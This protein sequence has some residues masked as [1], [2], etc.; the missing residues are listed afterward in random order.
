MPYLGDDVFNA[1]LDG[2]L[3]YEHLSLGEGFAR[4][5]TITN[6]DVGRFYPVFPFI[7][8]FDFHVVHDVTVLKAV[9]LAA[10][11]ANA[12]TFYALVRA[13]APSLALP[14]LVVLPATLQLRFFHDAI[15]QF[16]LHMQVAFEFALLG[17]LCVVV[18]ARSRRIVLAVLSVTACALAALTYEATYA[19]AVIYVF[20]AGTLVPDVRARIR[21]CIAYVLV[22][23]GCCA[24]VLAVR[25]RVPVASG[26]SY[27]VNLDAAAV[28]HTVWLQ[29]LGALPLSYAFWNPTGFLPPLPQLWDGLACWGV[30][31]IEFGLALAVLLRVG[32]A[33]DGGREGTAFVLGTLLVTLSG[34]PIAVLA[35]WQRELG[36]GL[37]YT[38]VYF[39][40]F[41]MALVIAAFGFAVVRRLPRVTSAV[42]LALAAAFLAGTTY[43]ANGLVL[44]HYVGWS[45]VVPRALDA[46]L[47]SNARTG[48]TVYLDDSYPAHAMKTASYYL[49]KH[50]HERLTARRQVD[51]P[52]IVGPGTF[53]LDGSVE[54]FKTGRVVAGRIVSVVRVAGENVPLVL[55]A[56][57][58]VAGAGGATLD[59]IRSRCGLLPLANL[60]DDIP[61]ALLVRYGDAFSFPERDGDATFR[62]ASEAGRV[63]VDNP[64]ARARR[65]TVSFD[66]RPAAATSHVSVRSGTFVLD[67]ESRGGDVP[68]TLAVD[69]PAHASTAISIDSDGP[70]VPGNPGGRILRYQIRGLRLAEPG[71]EVVRPTQPRRRFRKKL[72]RVVADPF[73]LFRR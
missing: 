43:G 33:R 40:T 46:G 7:M 14:A 41:G 49:L 28:A 72:K 47:L 65:A 67:R 52:A 58:F 69:V 34:I 29:I 61:S 10:I 11:V 63:F 1:Y 23:L 70:P 6:T 36:P 12:L 73:D 35:R 21:L 3:G 5:F 56:R 39:E 32:P 38:P 16:S 68:A 31:G 22:P 53:A 30:A 9:V 51:L 42:V 2:W 27:A 66:V 54:D 55:S 25:T 50:T 20:L 8:F 44:A 13:I 45:M 64:T 59:T 62:W 71:C 18:F 19:Y 48:D 17:M 26:G 37:A 57:R 4:F 60:R 24:I 15:L